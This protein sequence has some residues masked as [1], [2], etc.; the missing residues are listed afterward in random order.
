MAYNDTFARRVVEGA[1]PYMTRSS[2]SR[3]GNMSCLR[4]RFFEPLSS[5]SV[6]GVTIGRPPFTPSFDKRTIKVKTLSSFVGV[7]ALDDPLRHTFRHTLFRG[8]SA[9]YAY[10]FQTATIK[11][12]RQTF[13]DA[14]THFSGRALI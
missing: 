7:G 9:L 1:D 6:V 8:I 14:C 12:P 3:Q 11:T 4:E 13:A 2:L 5:A 10:S